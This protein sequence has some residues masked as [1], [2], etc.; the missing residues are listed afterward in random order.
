MKNVIS[1]LLI[2]S[3][4]ILVACAPMVTSQ[5]SVSPPA[6]NSALLDVWVVEY[7]GDRP[8][9]DRS[10]ARIQFSDDGAIAGNA[11]CNRFF[12]KYRYTNQT[13]AIDP[14]GSTR[15]M[16]L[17]ALMEQEQRLLE[18]LPKATRV[19]IENGLLI[20]RDDTGQLVIQ[21]SREEP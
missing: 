13:L 4:I 10:P 2:L 5:D 14:L 8:V 21:A 3:A 1:S 12:G 9:V 16:C 15:M 6:D 20:L 18:Q 19:T 17:P 11:S 7:I